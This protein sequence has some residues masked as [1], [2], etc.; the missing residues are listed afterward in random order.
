MFSP[1]G[2]VSALGSGAMSGL[3]TGM[4]LRDKYETM[5]GQNILMGS[6]GDILPGLG[7]MSGMGQGVPA[8]QGIGSQ[9]GV[10]SAPMPPVG[11]PGPPQGAG[12]P[13]P[14]AAPIMPA[15]MQPGSASAGPGTMRPMAPPMPGTYYPPGGGAPQVTPQRPPQPPPAQPP[16]S[17]EDQQGAIR[18]AQTGQGWLS[19]QDLA[20]RIND[21]YPDASPMA[22]FKAMEQ[23]MK[24]LNQGSQQQFQQMM[25]MMQFQQRERFHADTMKEKQESDRRA[26]ER[27]G[28]SERRAD[29]AAEKMDPQYQA[30]KKAVVDLQF[31]D[32][33]AEV[34]SKTMVKHLDQLIDLSKKVNVTG[35]MP[36]DKWLGMIKEK[37]G[38]ETMFAYK[39]QLGLA[40]GE[41]GK[42]L[43]GGTGQAAITEGVRKEAHDVIPYMA[44][45]KALERIKQLLLRDAQIKRQEYEN[46][47]MTRTNRYNE[48]KKTGT[49]RATEEDVAAPAAAAGTPAGD[50]ADP[51]GLN[52]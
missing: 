46:E 8:A 12:G 1:L 30:T 42:M 41:I 16:P 11:A 20:K 23:G 50:A 25:Q 17:R 5:Q 15:A 14:Q 32:S 34:F 3:E 2:A 24:L 21:K 51:L 10:S 27:L 43:G 40:Q 22:K 38:E 13:G 52:R 28:I 45:T 47:I 37:F 6:L 19:T 48:Y 31:K 9:P 18:F 36:V 7:A 4:E 39:A 44:P 35:V 49:M 33:Q 29:Q 26:D